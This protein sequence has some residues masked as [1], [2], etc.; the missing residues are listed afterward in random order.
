MPDYARQTPPLST[1]IVFEAAA[2]LQSFSRAADECALSQ[3]SVSRQIRQLEDNLGLS[4]FERHR[5]DVSPT[6]AGSRLYDTV[7]RAL[8]ELA[9][10][11]ED[12]R[13][14]AQGINSFTIYS[15]IAIGTSVLAPL[16]GRIQAQHPHVRFNIVSSYDPIEQ[17]HS[18][19]DI[20]FQAGRRAEDIFDVETIADDLVFPVCSPEFAEQ[21]KSKITAE[22]LSKLPLLHLDYENKQ[23]INWQKF[24]THYRIRQKKPVERLVFS[25]YQVSLDVAESGEGVALGWGRSVSSRMAAGRLIRFTDMAVHVPDG[26]SVYKRK[27]IDPHPLASRIIELIRENIECSYQ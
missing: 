7:Q 15:D 20:G 4:L 16:I 19:F 11:A 6:D 26:I 12:L 22:K 2:R 25:A 17:T 3:A 1:L 9:H 5:Y 23:S 14:Q 10:T 21:F 13:R 8:R 27:Q 18:S 24:L